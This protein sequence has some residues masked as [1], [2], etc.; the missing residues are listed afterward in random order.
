MNTQPF[1]IERTLDA[2]VGKV[3]KA[4]T[5]PAEMKKWYFDLPGFTATPGYEFTF[6]GGPDPEHQYI[7]LCRVTIAEPLKK[8]AH[9]W[10]YKGYPG[11]SEVT[12]ELFEEGEKTRLK[13]THAGLETLPADNP[14]LARENFEAGWSDIIGTSLP[15][16]LAA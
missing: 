10:K 1:V 6:N 5:D 4:I 12:F 16:Y 15:A 8:L 2:P 11:N 14:D 7:H 13:L 3:W 9:T